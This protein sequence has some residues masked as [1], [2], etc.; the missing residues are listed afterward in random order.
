MKLTI[1][2]VLL[3]RGVSALEQIDVQNRVTVT[4]DRRL[5]DIIIQYQGFNRQ[6]YINWNKPSS[7]AFGIEEKLYEIL[8]EVNE[9][10]ETAKRDLLDIFTIEEAYPDIIFIGGWI[11]QWFC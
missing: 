4:L 11:R 8:D 6:N 10:V 3:I 2:D 5:I 9:M 1:D 7:M